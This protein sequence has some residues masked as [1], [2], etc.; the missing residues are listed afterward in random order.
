MAT[1]S[2]GDT[3]H[4]LMH[5][6]RRQLRRSIR[7]QGITL[8]VTHIRI[9]K[10]IGSLKATTAREVARRIGTDKAQV[11]RALN[12]LE[13]MAQISRQRDPEDRRSQIL[14]IT[15]DGRSTL[16]QI[17]TAEAQA[18]GVMSDSLSDAELDGFREMASTMIRNTLKDT[19][20][21]ETETPCP[22]R[23]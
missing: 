20:D 10:A 6:Y 7:D 23:N 18:A 9:L 11:T 17:L 14:A 13:A 3:L 8:P 21:T 22:N 15:E 1:D 12:E 19:C 16:D 5:A 4:Q 2:I